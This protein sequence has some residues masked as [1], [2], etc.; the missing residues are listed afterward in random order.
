MTWY[1]HITISICCH[2]YY[3]W[4]CTKCYLWLIN[5]IIIFTLLFFKIPI[6]TLPSAKPNIISSLYGGHTNVVIDDDAGNLLHIVF[7]SL[8]LAPI[9]YTYTILS[10]YATAIFVESYENSIALTTYDFY[11]VL[12]DGFVGKLS[13]FPNWSL[14]NNIF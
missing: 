2:T 4:F 3:I 12:S 8:N 10:D 1:N 6:L 7:F 14:N 13:S 11:Y 5:I 9:L